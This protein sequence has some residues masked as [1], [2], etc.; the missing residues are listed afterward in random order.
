MA[1]TKAR[2][3][4]HNAST[5]TW[6][7]VVMTVATAALLMIGYVVVYSSSQAS[8]LAAAD[9]AGTLDS[10]NAGSKLMFQML[11]SLIGAIIAICAWR[12][13]PDFWRGTPLTVVF[14]VAMA[15]LVATFVAGTSALGATRW[16][17]LGPIS[18]QP[19]EFAKIAFV[20]LACRLTDKYLAGEFI[21]AQHFGLT[22]AVLIGLPLLFLYKSQS[23]LG[24]TIIIVVAFLA[25]AWLA[26][27]PW[28][29]FRWVLLA[30]AIFGCIA[31]FG[32]GYRTDRM[33][34]YDPW[35]DGDGGYGNGYQTIH[36]FYAF[37]QGGLFGVGLGNSTE[38]FD[39]LPEAETDFV[40]SIIGEEFGMLGALIVIALFMVLLYCGLRIA[41]GASTP[42]GTMLAGSCTIMLVFQAFLNMG[43]VIGMVPTTG[44]PLPFIS[45]GG[46]S[47]IASLILVGLIL[48]VA[49]VSDDD[50]SVYER[51]RANLRVVRAVDDEEDV[52]P[53]GSRCRRTRFA[54]DTAGAKISRSAN[55]R[56]LSH[57][58][59]A[60]GSLGRTRR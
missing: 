1:L 40:F 50:E 59:P 42:H 30:L 24:T 3:R 21:S 43:C 8:I 22:L 18:L 10:A 37:A 31:I 57:L 7:Q 60:R 27:M 49:H 20:L 51:R 47:V 14:A 54:A 15:L 5:M 55:I 19:S 53:E 35:N 11:Y 25:I 39:Y 26:G 38:K 32:T 12:I 36:S 28:K 16:L 46:S 29:I 4:A 2:A 48:S 17:S 34:V 6:L 13:N 45:Y 23:D 41:H 33:V 44:K 56:S 58:A 52:A 9:V